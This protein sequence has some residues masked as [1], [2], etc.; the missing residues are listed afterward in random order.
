MLFIATSVPFL[1][2]NPFYKEVKLNEELIP[3]FPS[4]PDIFYLKTEILL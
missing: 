1:D 2:T 3:Y 4:S